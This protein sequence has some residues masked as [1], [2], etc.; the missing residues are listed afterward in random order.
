MNETRVLLRSRF[1]PCSVTQGAAAIHP[2]TAG[3][4]VIR[5]E[6][7]R[8]STLIE[9]LAALVIA[10]LFFF[11]FLSVFRSTVKASARIAS[12]LLRYRQ[13]R[14][15]FLVFERD[16]RNTVDTF[17][18]PFKGEEGKCSFITFQE[19]PFQVDY[20]WKNGLLVRRRGEDSRVLLVHVK[21]FSLEYAYKDSDRGNIVFLPIWGEIS[22][23]GPPAFLRVSFELDQKGEL[24][25]FSKMVDIPQ[26][27]I[28][29]LTA[30]G[31]R[32]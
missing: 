17:S 1:A 4:P 28:G 3:D 29:W 21:K 31:K 25:P 16:L 19:R 7:P 26:G 27:Q 2:A 22:D 13:A 12:N 18:F 32:A 30:G 23:Q 10:S 20:L 24:V 15:F 5:R 11:T 14:S 6:K 8:G 9:L